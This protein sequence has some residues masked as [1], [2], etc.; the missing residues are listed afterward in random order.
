MC[1]SCNPICG[2]CRP[3]RIR[4]I[5]CPECGGFN[6]CDIEHLEDVYECE[7]CGADITELAMPEPAICQLCGEICYNPC[8]RSRTPLDSGIQ[9]CQMRVTEPLNPKYQ[10]APAA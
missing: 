9:S 2:G 6:A 7:S 4:A 10:K 3:P 5:Q 8:K 1:W